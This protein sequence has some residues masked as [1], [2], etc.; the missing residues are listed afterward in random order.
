M[1]NYLLVGPLLLQGFE[2]PP[3]IAWGGRQRVAVHHMPGGRRVLDSM[4]RDDAEISW[5]G[6]FTGSGAGLRAR[7]LDLMRAD[8]SVWPLAWD[9]FFYSVV[10]SRFAAEFERENWIPYSIACTVLRDE[11]E[12]LVEDAISLAGSLTADLGAADTLIPGT[13][14]ADLPASR[15]GLGA[16][17]VSAGAGLLGLDPTTPGGLLAARDASGALAQQSV[18]LG[19]VNRA[20]ANVAIDRG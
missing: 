19:Y 2:L 3:S 10:V 20:S 6:I 4:G 18:A 8:G 16:G 12:G 11:A 13:G 15:A 14:A 5:S 1:S 9:S 17:V 7:M